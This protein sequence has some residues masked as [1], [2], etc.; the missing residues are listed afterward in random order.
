MSSHDTNDMNRSRE[1]DAGSVPALGENAPAPLPRPEPG[2]PRPYRFPV[3]ERA[4]LENG[5]GVIV[6]PVR[7]L[8]LATVML[9]SDAGASAE[10]GGREGV[11]NLT[12]RALLEGTKGRGS[13]VTELFERLGASIGAGADWD[14]STV[15]MTVLTSRL[16]EAMQL[17]GEVVLDP[18]FP[19]RELERLRAERLADILQLTAEPRGLA[20]EM[21]SRVLYEQ[22]SRYARPED[23]SAGTVRVLGREDVESFYAARYQPSVSTLIVVGDV[24]VDDGVK[25]ARE[26]LGGWKGSASESPPVK[27][28]PAHTSRAVHIVPK[29][30]APQ[31]ELRMGHIGLPRA[32][33]DYFPVL[34][35][36]SVLGGLF[37]SRINLNLR[38]VHGYT[39]GAFSGY[40]WRRGP[41]PFVVSTAVKSDVTAE[42]AREILLEI[43]RMRTDTISE[44][45]LS[46]ATSYLGG[47]FPIRYETTDAIARALSALVTYRLPEDY[48]DS[49]R[50]KVRAVTK[51]DVLQA[52]DR[53]LHPEEL[54]LL[55]VGDPEVVR[56]PLEELGFGPVEMLPA[57]I[58]ESELETAEREGGR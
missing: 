21:F 48:F 36:N 15:A 57:D 20:N 4:T 5:L 53:H 49:Y 39:Y 58:E 25:L 2:A 12:A 55:V 41:G 19:E 28:A 54:Q 11:A 14:V 9:V 44:E 23:G 6:A 17:F 26:T 22:G 50:D 8:P 16:K 18:S 47:V 3:F 42:S 45:E 40:A 32:H 56:A 46:L 27:T 30:E 29:A 7:A 43:E 34:V 13:D 33:P 24:S 35:M 10:P 52:A 38:E 51:V 37:S 1:H 31:S